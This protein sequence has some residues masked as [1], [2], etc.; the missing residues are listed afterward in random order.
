[1][2]FYH[3]VMCPKDA[4]GMTNSVDPDQTAPLSGSRLFAQIC[5]SEHLGALRYFYTD[6]TYYCQSRFLCYQPMSSVYRE[7]FIQII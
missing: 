1:M 4:D 3:R 7:A 5:L 6:L 2:W